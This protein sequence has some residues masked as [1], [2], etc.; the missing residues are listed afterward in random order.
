MKRRAWFQ[1]PHRDKGG[2]LRFHSSGDGGCR[3]DGNPGGLPVVCLKCAEARG[4]R[5]EDLLAR[6][7]RLAGGVR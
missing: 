5:T 6:I 3:I 2:R 4:D 1:P 7:E